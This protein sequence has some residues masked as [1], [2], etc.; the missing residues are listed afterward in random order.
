MQMIWCRIKLSYWPNYLKQKRRDKLTVV[1]LST[2]TAMNVTYATENP[3]GK[4]D[5][6]HW[7]QG[8]HPLRVLTTSDHKAL[9]LANMSTLTYTCRAALDTLC[10]WAKMHAVTSTVEGTATSCTKSSKLFQKCQNCVRSPL[11]L[12]IYRWSNI[13]IQILE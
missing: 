8:Q 12:I 3:L 1:A 5:Q 10:S 6:R 13:L 2:Q 7:T 9:K 4:F 11:P